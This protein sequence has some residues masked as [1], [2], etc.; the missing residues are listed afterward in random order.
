[1]NIEPNT[2]AFLN[3][4][5]KKGGP[6]IYELSITDAR[7]MLADAQSG[8]VEKMPAEIEDLTIDCGP[9]GKINIRIIR[10]QGKKEVLPVVF[11][12]H[13]G[14][15]ILGDKGTHDRLVREIAN[16]AH[17]AVVFIEFSR[18][19]EFQYP[20]PLEE[21]YAAVKYMLKQC[22]SFHLGFVIK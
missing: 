1:M 20:I 2:Q 14:G 18:S 12:F 4:V 17:A 8:P 22:E 9:T 7:K 3:A 21:A 11:Y 16:G 5:A 10:P 13:G 19:P 15:W 6:E